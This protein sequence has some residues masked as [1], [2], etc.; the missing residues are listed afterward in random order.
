MLTALVAAALLLQEA[1]PSRAAADEISPDPIICRIQAGSGTRF[2]TRV[3]MTADQWSQRRAALERS[4]DRYRRGGGTIRARDPGP[5][6]WT[7]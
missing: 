1:P 7:H 3:C 4:P 6:R 5:G 2:T